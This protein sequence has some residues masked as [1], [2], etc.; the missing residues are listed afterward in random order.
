MGTCRD[1]PPRGA[2]RPVGLEPR[3]GVGERGPAVEPVTIERARGGPIDGRGEIVV[4]LGFEGDGHRPVL[5][6]ETRAAFEDHLD[7]FDGPA[8]RLETRP[9]PRT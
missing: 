3:G 9:R 1:R 7:P 5:R 2:V 8:P 6:L 4:T